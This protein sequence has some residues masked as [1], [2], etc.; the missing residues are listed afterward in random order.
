MGLEIKPKSWNLLSIKE[1]G[2]HVVFEVMKMVEIT[3]VECILDHI[4]S[5]NDPP[6]GYVYLFFMG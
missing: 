2:A 5:G 4:S 6:L 1:S 3:Q